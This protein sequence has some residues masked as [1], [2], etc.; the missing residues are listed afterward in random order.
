MSIRK[1]LQ[2]SKVFLFLSV[3]FMASHSQAAM[4]VDQDVDSTLFAPSASFAD[5]AFDLGSNIGD[6]FSITASTA[7]SSIKFWSQ[8]SQIGL[9]SDHLA[10]NIYA[11]DGAIDQT[12][13]MWSS[14]LTG[15][16]I[17]SSSTAIAD[18]FVHTVDTTG[19]SL[20]AG[21]YFLNVGGT[22]DNMAPMGW[23]R[24]LN[25]PDNTPGAIQY[26][27]SNAFGPTGLISDPG[28]A[29]DF[30]FQIEGTQ[31]TQPVNAPTSSALL[32]CLGLLMIGQRKRVNARKVN[33]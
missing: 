3:F 21:N 15:A 6:D 4:I 19:L 8:T 18:L 10:V 1:F 27:I 33:L 25:S 32:L 30:A 7:I 20:N 31:A 9:F 29:I 13:P 28:L 16:I 2:I 12:N 26:L 14:Q 5:V 22:L 17:S 23:A 24:A 11:D